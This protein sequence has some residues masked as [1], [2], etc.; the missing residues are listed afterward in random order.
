MDKSKVI[1]RDN[2]LSNS[3]DLFYNL[4]FQ[5]RDGELWMGRITTRFSNNKTIFEVCLSPDD[6]DFRIL[7]IPEEER[8]TALIE[9]LTSNAFPKSVQ[10]LI[11]YRGGLPKEGE[12]KLVDSLPKQKGESLDFVRIIP[13]S[14]NC[15]SATIPVVVGMNYNDYVRLKSIVDKADRQLGKLE[16]SIQDR[17]D[18]T[19]DI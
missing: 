13:N 19:V 11:E 1:I 10:N 3:P 18:D 8:I 14:R 9:F 2:S 16:S 12:L 7:N 15:E 17:F 4:F 6:E 5:N